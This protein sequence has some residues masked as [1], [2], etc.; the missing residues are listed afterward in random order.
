VL[1]LV[2]INIHRGINTRTNQPY[3]NQ[4]EFYS[5]VMTEVSLW[6]LVLRVF[7]YFAQNVRKIP[8]DRHVEMVVDKA[9]PGWWPRLIADKGKQHW[10]KV[11]FDKWVDEDDAG[12]ADDMDGPG[13]P[14]GG[15]GGGFGDLQS[16]RAHVHARRQ[17][18]TLVYR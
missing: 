9:E 18:R 17:M 15:G 6:R 12:Y 16:V 5:K 10:L 11:N 8:N 3:E 14:G 4:F 13:G 2:H 1:P 7:V